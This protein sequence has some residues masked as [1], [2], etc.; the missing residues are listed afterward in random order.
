M[1]FKRAIY[2]EVKRVTSMLI[3]KDVVSEAWADKLNRLVMER[4]VMVL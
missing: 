4:L 3:I 2:I 1:H